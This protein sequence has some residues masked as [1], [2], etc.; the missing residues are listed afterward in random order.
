MTFSDFAFMSLESLPND[1][2][3]ESMLVPIKLMFRFLRKSYLSHRHKRERERER[4]RES[5]PICIPNI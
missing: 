2:Q 3:L 5:I 4:E 1:S